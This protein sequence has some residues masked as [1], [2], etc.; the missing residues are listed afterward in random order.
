M[1]PVIGLTAY[2]EPARWGRWELLATL[3]PQRYVE[4]L[5]ASGGRAVL[6]PPDLPDDAEEMVARLDG[7]VLT[8][9]ADIDPVHYGAQPHPATEAA[10]PERDVSELALLAAAIRRD[11]PVLGICRGMQLMAVVGGGTLHQHLPDVLGHDEHRPGDGAFGEHVVELAL[12]SRAADIL[13]ERVTVRSYHHQG[14]DSSGSATVSA[15]A[16]DGT[17][18]ALEL[19][20]HCFALG[21]LW[22]PEA[23]TDA[24]LFAA[25]VAAARAAQQ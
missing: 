11:L 7:L 9:G 4:H 25:L 19:P 24:R 10:R 6:L 2:I 23:G 13:G 14:V 21:V 22:H 18:E 5:A 16:A 8:G 3:L 15:W 12:G 20:G 17:I 1:R